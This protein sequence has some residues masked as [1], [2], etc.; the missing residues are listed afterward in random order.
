M[1]SPQKLNGGF[2]ARAAQGAM[3]AGR[4]ELF[5][6]TL[7]P[8]E[9]RE[10]PQGD[11]CKCA[12]AK[13]I[14]MFSSILKRPVRLALVMAGALALGAAGTALAAGPVVI[15][16]RDTPPSFYPAK[17]TIKAGQTVEWKNTG[18]TIH[19][20]TNNPDNVV[21]KTDVAVPGG[22]QPF[23]SGFVPPG[24]TY[25]YT[26]TKAGVYKY[27]CIPHEMAGMKGEITVA[28]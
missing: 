12:P 22:T 28:K 20:A 21:Q 5:E 15:Q 4:S 8:R 26:F 24:G 2:L 18:N 3:R 19:G 14:K 17:V 16:M 27:V 9:G 6:G 11:A 25:K 10:R 23:D 7:Q 1:A 13:E